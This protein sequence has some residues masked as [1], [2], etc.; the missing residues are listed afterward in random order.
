VGRHC[1][2]LLVESRR[3]RAA[4]TFRKSTQLCGFPSA[5]A[6]PGLLQ[7]FRGQFDAR[8]RMPVSVCRTLSSLLSYFAVS[9]FRQDVVNFR[10]VGAREGV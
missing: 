1:R 4:K 8:N 6:V 2:S 3:S 10:K 9:V 5:V 7:S